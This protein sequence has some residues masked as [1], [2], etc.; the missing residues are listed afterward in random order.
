MLTLPGRVIL[1][2][3]FTICMIATITIA[4][5]SACRHV[6]TGEALTLARE[7]I[8][9]AMGALE[10]FAEVWPRGKRVVKE[11]KIVARELLSLAPSSSSPSSSIAEKSVEMQ[12]I[13]DY[14]VVPFIHQN[15]PYLGSSSEGYTTDIDASSGYIEFPM[16][17]MNLDTAFPDNNGWGMRT[18]FSYDITAQY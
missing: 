15:S 1:H 4:H 18:G 10:I 5:L 9:V 7:R 12:S 2:T 16:G 8:R 11:V 3:P 13:P 17:D 14:N 6:L